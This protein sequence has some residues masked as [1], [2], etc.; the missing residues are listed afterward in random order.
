MTLVELAK[1]YFDGEL[2]DAEVKEI[3]KDIEI[4][5]PDTSLHSDEFPSIDNGNSWFEVEEEVDISDLDKYYHFV[6]LV[7]D[8]SS[9]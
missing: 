5:K 6:A 2:K 4:Y 1:A 7:N 8:K 3:A 9:I